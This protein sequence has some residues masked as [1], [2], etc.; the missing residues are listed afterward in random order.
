MRRA[1]IFLIAL[2]LGLTAAGTAL[3]GKWPYIMTFYDEA[4]NAVGWQIG[5]CNGSVH[6]SGERTDDYTIE[7]LQ[8]PD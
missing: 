4:G 2:V 6:Y 5:A 7:R 1:R 8:C 3:A